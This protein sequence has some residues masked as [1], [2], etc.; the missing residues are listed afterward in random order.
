M[1]PKNAE[2]Q[3]LKI[4]IGM[5]D[6][7]TKLMKNNQTAFGLSCCIIYKLD[8]SGKVDQLFTI[9]IAQMIKKFSFPQ[10]QKMVRADVFNGFFGSFYRFGSAAFSGFFRGGTS[11]PPQA[12]KCVRTIF[13]IL[14][15]VGNCKFE[16]FSICRPPWLD[17]EFCF[18]MI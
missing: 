17:N 10:N 18:F 12:A 14:H 1:P 8:L 6:R 3:I 4:I 15:H 5:N 9:I 7:K 16:G 2:P 11:S 13:R